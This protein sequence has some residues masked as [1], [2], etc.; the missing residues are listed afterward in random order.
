[1][2][3]PQVAERLAVQVLVGTSVNVAMP[4]VVNTGDGL[5]II[6]RANIE[7]SATPGTF[8]AI[9]NSPVLPSRVHSYAY[10]KTA[11]GSEGGGTV[12]FQFPVSATMRVWVYRITAGSWRG[13][14]AAIE[15]TGASHDTVGQD[16]DPPSL[17]PSWGA[18][19]N[20]WVISGGVRSAA[21]TTVSYPS[22]YSNG[23]SNAFIAFVANRELN[24]TTED[25]G[26]FDID[27]ANAG[28]S[29]VTVAIRGAPATPSSQMLWENAP[30]RKRRN[31][32]PQDLLLRSDLAQ[33]S[34]VPNVRLRGT[35]V[36]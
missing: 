20:L 14:V 10:A 25:P 30:L 17:T 23:D 16:P 8:T 1:M 29:A 7:F 31:L 5:L 33:L 18:D 28:F 22:G 24:A 19:D 9:A 26:V 32:P 35:I 27:G 12:N 34:V 4:A 6:G 3:F 11:D 13:L 15:G 2:P 36:M 21:G